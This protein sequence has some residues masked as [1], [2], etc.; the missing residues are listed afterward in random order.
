ML[1]IVDSYTWPN[2]DLPFA[3]L[4]LRMHDLASRFGVAVPTRDDWLGPARELRFRS[5]SGRVYLLQE[6]EWSI[7]HLGHTGPE[8]HVDVA[9]LASSGVEALVN[10]VV[11]SLGIARRDVA[12]VVDESIQQT[13]ADVVARCSAQRAE[14]GPS[15]SEPSE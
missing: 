14:G 1:E 12:F 4:G 6:S 5:A 3:V 2:D 10:D 8:V 9:E 13:A 15:W 11:V 7:R